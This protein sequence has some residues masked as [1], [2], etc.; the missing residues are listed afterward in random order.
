MASDRQTTTNAF[1]RA[2]A[3]FVK[4]LVA[5]YPELLQ[6]PGFRERYGG[7]A[8]SESHLPDELIR[9]F[10]KRTHPIFYDLLDRQG[11]DAF[12]S[13]SPVCLLPHIDFA[14]V[15]R[16]QKRQPAA[17]KEAFW[18]HLHTLLFLSMRYQLDGRWVCQQAAALGQNNTSEGR[19]KA[20]AWLMYIQDMQGRNDEI[21]K[22]MTRM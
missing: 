6:A 1:N 2:A 19:Q 15:W 20:A 13:P 11:N 14:W 16:M 18:R 4:E 3:R 21:V 7:G 10:G 8:Q 12:V 5:S 22:R 17:S 9:Q